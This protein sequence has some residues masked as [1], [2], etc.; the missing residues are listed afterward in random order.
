[1]KQL[2][3][4][5]DVTRRKWLI[6]G[7]GKVATRRAQQLVDAEGSFDLIARRA[8]ERIIALCNQSGGECQLRPWQPEDLQP[9]YQYVVAAT[10][11]VEIN[12][13][14]ANLCRSAG[15]AVNVATDSSLCDFSF[16]ATI[17]RSPITI[18]VSSG[19]ASPILARLLSER[20]DALIP[21][22]YGKLAE[23]IK[24]YRPTVRS[25]LSQA[26]LRKL[27]WEKV[28]LG[29]V[30]ESVFSGKMQHAEQLLEETLHQPQEQMKQ[31]EV[32][33]I[34][35]GPGDPDLLTFRAFRLLQQA[36]VVLYDRLVSEKILQ[37]VNQD[38]EL[39]Y[40]GKKRSNHAV[41]QPSINQRLLDYALEGKRVAR[42]KGGDPFIF[43]RGG[44]EIE[45]LAKHRVPFQVVPGI[46]AA[47]GCASYSGIPLTH[48]DHAQS[49]RFVTG[50]LKDGTVDLPW[51]DLVGESQ[52][53]VIYMGL[54][55]LPVISQ[56]LIAHGL[57]SETPAAL[58]EQG[59]TLSQ[60]IYCSTLSELPKLMQSQKVSPPTLMIIGSV[61]SLHES[62][63]WF[64]PPQNDDESA[65]SIGN[66]ADQFHR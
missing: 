44:E 10:D 50:Q 17:D 6:I 46:T 4:F 31:G 24:K 54:N 60:K 2:P 13:E 14:I 47:S 27:F 3:L 65:P 62:L 52:T 30:A 53:L 61:V 37:Q 66:S 64:R 42:L 59:T 63:H 45:L 39:I 48:R 21:A 43:G 28:L 58:I 11:A 19:S 38:A 1:M 8:D 26:S 32:Y 35:A 51:K 55:G 41:P 40:V 7:G 15:I 29:S 49:V 56:Q 25:T 20:I 5:L 57:D 33:L 23:L 36:E 34:G 12:A 18:A 16:P 22:G 9:S